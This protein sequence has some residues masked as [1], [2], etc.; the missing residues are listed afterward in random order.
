VNGSRPQFAGGVKAVL[1]M[2]APGAGFGN[3]LDDRCSVETVGNFAFCSIDT[4]ESGAWQ[5]VV[6]FLAVDPRIHSPFIYKV[7]GTDV[8]RISEMQFFSC[9]V[10]DPY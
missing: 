9:K 8:Q 7:T 10:I 1:K 4:P 6:S 3:A 2:Y 5:V